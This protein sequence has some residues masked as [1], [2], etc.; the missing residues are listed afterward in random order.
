MSEHET[1]SY[2]DLKNVLFCSF[3]CYAGQK[4]QENF[5]EAYKKLHIP[6]LMSGSS[7]VATLFLFKLLF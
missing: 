4:L 3:W 7:N 2:K 5:L 1:T 6:V